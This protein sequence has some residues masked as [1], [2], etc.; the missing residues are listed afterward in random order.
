MLFC[1]VALLD[2]PLDP[3]TYRSIEG[4]SLGSIVQVPIRHQS[5]T[6]VVVEL[7]DDTPQIR[8][9]IR[10]V[11]E[12]VESESIISPPMLEM[13]KFMAVYYGASF[14]DCLRLAMPGGMMRR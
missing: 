8:G 5:L 1:R 14:G 6:G 9:R 12:V 11:L 2:K 7:S 13:L 4:V 10:E 3:L